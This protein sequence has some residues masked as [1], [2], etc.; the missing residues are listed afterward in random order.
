MWLAG[1]PTEPAFFLIQSF[2]TGPQVGML[3]GA[4]FADEIGR[5]SPPPLCTAEKLMNSPFE[6]IDAALEVV[7]VD[8][9]GAGAVPEVQLAA[10]EQPVHPDP[11]VRGE[12]LSDLPAVVGQPVRER[13]RLREQQQAE[14]S[15]R[16]RALRVTTFAGWKYSTPPLTK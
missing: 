7:A 12:V 14:R 11:A 1:E 9:L 16:C 15:R 10:R 5:R 6:S 8:P 3:G 2:Q 13:G 4:A